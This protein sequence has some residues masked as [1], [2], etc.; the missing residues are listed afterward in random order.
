MEPD[1]RIHDCEKKRIRPNIEKSFF[2]FKKKR[3]MK[4]II[5]DALSCKPSL[6]HFFEKKSNLPVEV[7]DN[8]DPKP[9]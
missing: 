3:Q 2:L 1:S 7:G 8:P 9:D 5:F 6:Q 4:K